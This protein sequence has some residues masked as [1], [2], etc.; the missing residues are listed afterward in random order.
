MASEKNPLEDYLQAKE[1]SGGAEFMKGLR[2]SVSGMGGAYGAGSTL[3]RKALGAGAAVA[4][5]SAATLAGLALTKVY[6]AATKS[7][8]FKS[9]LDENADLAQKY[10]EDP[11]TFNRMFS[12]LRTFNPAFSRDPIVAGS[13]MRQMTEDP[14]HAGTAAV[15]ALQH[16]DK[17]RPGIDAF[18]RAFSTRS[19]KK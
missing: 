5:A 11:K 15:E 2:G 18:A 19:E 4:G 1:A 7:R 12:T 10:E 9:M 8:D 16:R 13:Y 6:D 17:M 14:M 3:G